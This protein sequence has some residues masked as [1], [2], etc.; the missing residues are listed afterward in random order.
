MPSSVSSA[1]AL[2]TTHDGHGRGPRSEGVIAG[3][4]VQRWF[5]PGSTSANVGTDSKGESS[6]GEAVDERGK[7]REEDASEEAKRSDTVWL[8]E[9]EATADQKRAASR[10]RM[11]ARG[12]TKTVF[13]S[14]TPLAQ[15]FRENPGASSSLG[16]GD[17]RC[18]DPMQ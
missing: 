18:K 3:H 12:A 13:M 17:G 8:R 14:L 15:A 2:V 4:V 1:P 16:G 6:K 9:R 10:G 7:R 5:S 11:S